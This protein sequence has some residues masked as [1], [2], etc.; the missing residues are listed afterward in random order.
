VVNL[1]MG[2]ACAM[3]VIL[4]ALIFTLTL[5]QQRALRWKA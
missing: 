2:I 4:L 5:L 3:S 1:R